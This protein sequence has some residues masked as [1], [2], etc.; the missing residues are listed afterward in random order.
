MLHAAPRSIRGPQ[1]THTLVHTWK[2]KAEDPH[3][4]LMDEAEVGPHIVFPLA[5]PLILLRL[6]PCPD[7]SILPCTCFSFT[8][9]DPVLSP[10][11]SH[12]SG[13]L[14]SLLQ[15]PPLVY[16]STALLI[17]L[18]LGHSGT[19]IKPKSDTRSSRW[20]VIAIRLPRCYLS[21]GVIRHLYERP[22][23]ATCFIRHE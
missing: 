4:Y 9:R 5:S 23:A 15:R 19:I 3:T 20:R 13:K 17:D 11:F 1:W 6:F 21:F 7:R 22:H 12:F 18:T 16:F 14:C 8:L 2:G 10:L